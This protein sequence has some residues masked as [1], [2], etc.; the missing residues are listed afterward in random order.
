MRVRV[1]EGVSLNVRVFGT[2]AR[3]TPFLLVHGLSSN[4]R[5]WDGV[6][7]ALAGHP[8]YAVDLRSHGSSDS[9]PIGYDTATAAADLSAVCSEL[10][11]PPAIVAGQSWGGNVV[12]QLAARHPSRVAAL[13]LVDGGWIHLASR[14]P[15]WEACAAR[16]RPAD[17]SA[18]TATALRASLRASHRDWEPWAIEATIGNLAVGPDDSLRRRLPVDRHMSILRSMWDDPPQPYYPRVGVPVLAIPAG[19]TDPDLAGLRDV[20]IRPYPGG[21]HDLHAQHPASIAADLL[22]LV[23]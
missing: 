12:V 9:P 15:S 23:P 21:D 17:V 16:L 13:A 22:G 10:D 4:A 2:D 14:F 3:G 11:L 1:G 5:L 8:V 20:K 19:S 18:I 6:A 7:H